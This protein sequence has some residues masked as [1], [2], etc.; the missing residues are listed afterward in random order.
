MLHNH[1]REE[2]GVDELCNGQNLLED[3]P[4]PSLTTPPLL[5][6]LCTISSQM[7]NE[8]W[9]CQSLRCLGR[10]SFPVFYKC[11]P[12]APL[13]DMLCNSLYLIIALQQH[14]KCSLYP[15]RSAYAKFKPDLNPDH[16]VP[17]LIPSPR[18]AMH[19]QPLNRELFAGHSQKRNMVG[20]CCTTILGRRRRR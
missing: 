1:S 5:E 9:I 20:Q 7:H 12:H 17:S 10:V 2:T 6:W 3:S 11:E 19:N 15:L 18:T 13:W 4:N 14:Y 16:Y 8:F